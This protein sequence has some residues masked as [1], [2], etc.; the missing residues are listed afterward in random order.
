MVEFA[1]SLILSKTKNPK[2]HYLY[3]IGKGNKFVG[4]ICIWKNSYP[5]MAEISYHIG[6]EYS[7]IQIERGKEEIREFPLIRFEW[8]VMPKIYQISIKNNKFKFTN[9]FFFWGGFIHASKT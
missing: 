2:D 1:D 4:N 8:K 5:T 3:Y 6:E 9:I 7:I